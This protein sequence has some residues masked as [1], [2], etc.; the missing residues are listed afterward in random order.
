[1]AMRIKLLSIA[2][3][4]DSK[5]LVEL[6]QL[7]KKDPGVDWE[8]VISGYS[9]KE[10]DQ[11]WESLQKLGTSIILSLDKVDDFN[12]EELETV[13]QSL[14][15]LVILATATVV[16][17]TAQ[18][19]PSL[20]EISILFHDI[21]PSIPS[22]KDKLKDEFCSLFETFWIKEK[23]G[24][25]DLIDNTILYLFELNMRPKATLKM[26]KRLWQLRGAFH[27]IEFDDPSTQTLRD[28]I[29]QSLINPN[30]M[31][32]DEGVRILGSILPLN[33]SFMKTCHEIIKKNLL[34]VPRNLIPKYGQV[35]FRAWQMSNEQVRPKLETDCIQDIMYHAIHASGIQLVKILRKILDYI[36]R[37]KRQKGVDEMLNRLYAPILW[38]SLKAANSIVRLNSVFLFVDVFPL[39]NPLAGVEENNDLL[40]NQFNSFDNLLMDSCPSIRSRTILGV[41]QILSAYWQMIP[42]EV[43]KTYITTLIE[44]LAW[45][46]AAAE[47]RESVLKGIVLLFNC[48]YCHL[49]LQ[50]I[51]P[52]LQNLFHDTSEKVRIAMVNLLIKVKGIRKIKYWSIVSVEH[53]LVR[54]AID[55]QPVA[56]RIMQII[57]SSFLPLDKSAEVQVTRI[58]CLIETNPKAS[59][60]FFQHAPKQMSLEQVVSFIV[61]LCG[62]IL[63]CIRNEKV[64]S[65]ES[66]QESDNHK[67]ESLYQEQEGENISMSLEMNIIHGFLDAITILWTV[68]EPE[69]TKPSSKIMK[70]KL[71]KIFSKSIPVIMR[72]FKD[73]KSN[74]ALIIIASKLP[75]KLVPYL[76]HQCLT[77]LKKLDEETCCKEDYSALIEMSC[78]WGKMNGLLDLILEW[79]T[80][81]MKNKLDSSSTFKQSKRQTQ[82]RFTVNEVSKPILALKFLFHVVEQPNC[83]ALLLNKH[84]KNILD[85]LEQLKNVLKLLE[86]HFDTNNQELESTDDRFLLD[87]YF[88][89]IRLNLL[90]YM[91][92][93]SQSTN[94][95]VNLQKLIY[96]FL[97]WAKKKVIPVIE[98]NQDS[99]KSTRKRN[100]SHSKKKVIDLACDLLQNLFTLFHTYLLMYEIDEQFCIQL[101]TLFEPCVD[102]VK[103]VKL[104]PIILNCIIQLTSNQCPERKLIVHQVL[105]IFGNIIQSL[106]RQSLSDNN[107]DSFSQIMTSSRMHMSNFL[108]AVF[109]LRMLSPPL[110][111]EFYKKMVVA[112][113]Y[114][115]TEASKR[116]ELNGVPNAYQDLKP[117]ALWLLDIIFKKISSVSYFFQELQKFIKADCLNEEHQFNALLFMLNALL[118]KPKNPKLEIQECW[119]ALQDCSLFP[120]QTD[121]DDTSDNVGLKESLKD[122]IEQLS[123]VMAIKSS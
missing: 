111:T 112:V 73:L 74:S 82:V 97:S 57:F 59:R 17:N 113:L 117:F 94:D 61:L 93:N 54:L 123:S 101:G 107:V 71:D 19:P 22:R 46:G 40:Q 67:D 63:R 62:C 16:S 79:L 81:G 8:E 100:S 108:A 75:P 13:F 27:L 58:I 26:I 77:K 48:H 3:S 49:I 38:R 70:E 80:D 121:L 44:D 104:L 20:L 30:F 90:V 34:T 12:E 56:R 21:L 65:D 103:S 96:Q 4:E 120:K 31:K 68:V 88:L 18:I 2:Q 86:H 37:Q 87:A 10:L 105:S 84:Q 102:S 29:C 33:A 52:Q 99:S 11:L 114:E 115:L 95:S 122:H 64:A 110:L 47:V 15:C 106:A 69:L 39:Q 50:P 6:V 45:D 85:I 116:S 7:G 89:Y 55:T 28:Q 83:R 92:V 24:R 36:H 41:C 51:L 25:Q 91:E 109:D 118:L 14:Q 53:L 43:I 119:T 32:R 98:N 35:Y 23:P 76:S 72:H 66:F 1:M 5:K 78:S 9:R 60:I 42:K